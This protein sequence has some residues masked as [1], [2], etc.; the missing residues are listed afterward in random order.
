MNRLPFCALVAFLALGLRPFLSQAAADMF[1]IGANSFEIEFVTVGQPG[2]PPD[3][4][5]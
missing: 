5:G 2:N 1:G 4:T 3:L